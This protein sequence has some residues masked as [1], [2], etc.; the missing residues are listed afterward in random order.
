[1]ISFILMSLA[2]LW[3]LMAKVI[4]MLFIFSALFG[5]AYGGSITTHSPLVAELFGL[6]S[7]GLIFGVAGIGFSLGG[8]AGP[9]LTGHIFDITG[10]Y[11]TAFQICSAVGITGVLTTI[12]IKKLS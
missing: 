3:L 2:M 11:Q 4:W 6:N 1:M 7:H 5:F 8:A 10:N 9:L 12:A